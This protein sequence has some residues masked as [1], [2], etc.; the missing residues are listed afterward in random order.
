[1]I[2]IKKE[3]KAKKES[4]PPKQ[5]FIGS[6]LTC[7]KY[8]RSMNVSIASVEVDTIAGKQGESSA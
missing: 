3:T 4:P 2:P 1:M 8:S 6:A 7:F 5:A